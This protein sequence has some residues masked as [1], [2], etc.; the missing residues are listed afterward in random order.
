MRRKSVQ[1]LNQPPEEIMRIDPTNAK[2]GQSRRDSAR[3]VRTFAL[4]TPFVLALSL[5]SYRMLAQVPQPVLKIAPTNGTQLNISIT[6]AIAS[7]NYEIYWTPILATNFPWTL[8]LVGSVGQSNFVADMGIDTV[9]FYKAG[10]GSDWDIDTFPNYM[11]A[12]P[13]DA[14][15]GALSLTIDSPTN[16]ASLQ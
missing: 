13:F 7:T 16:G 5:V 15:I 3:I 9:G 14:T 10:I 6:N 11:D 8:L 2:A 4:A 12:N 1:L